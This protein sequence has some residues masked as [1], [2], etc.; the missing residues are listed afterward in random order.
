[1]KKD[2]YKPCPKLPKD[3]GVSSGAYRKEKRIVVEDPLSDTAEWAPIT[4]FDLLG[5]NFTASQRAVIKGF[6][7]PSPIQAQSWPIALSGRD[8]VG[9][10]Q[11]GSGKTIAFL[12]P[13]LVHIAAQAPLTGGGGGGSGPI[14][15]VLSPTRELAMQ[16]AAVAESAGVACG[17]TSICIY[18]GV[19]KGPQVAALTGRHGGTHIVVATPGRLRDLMDTAGVSLTRVTLVVLDEADRMLDEGFEREVRAILGA[20]PAAV[21]VG[22]QTL[23]FSATWPEGVRGIAAAFMRAPVRVT[24]GSA[25][26]SA[27]HTVTQRVEVLDPAA[28]DARLVKLLQQYHSGRTNRCLVFVLYKKEADRVSQFLERGGWKNCAIHGDMSQDARTRSFTAFKSGTIPLLVATD[29]AARGLDIPNVEFVINYSFPLTI[30][31]YI[32]R[33]GR[34]GRGGKTGIAHTFFTVN[35]KSHSGEL[36]NVLKEAG[37]EVPEDLVNKFGCTVSDG[38][39]CC[40]FA[41][42]RFSFPP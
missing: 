12:L 19:P 42:A 37:A 38:R 23:M 30:E 28:R 26:L 22:R 3:G 35:D 13:G 34:T 15:L 40:V 6:K 9:I 25:E 5:D 2:F 1:V 18:G 4:T 33:I 29:V 10:A 21:G 32:H 31:D 7:E 11:T 39:C 8:M 36:V 16:T 41:H 20:I 14:M 17:L 24:I 27:S